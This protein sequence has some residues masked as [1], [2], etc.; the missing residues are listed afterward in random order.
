MVKNTVWRNTIKTDE[1]VGK[2]IEIL[3]IDWT[4]TEA[5][6]YANI[7]RS[8]YYD[9]IKKDKEFSNKM[10]DA[11]KY[12]FIEARKTINKAIK[13][14]DWKLALDVMRR[15]DKRYKDKEE[16]E[17]SWEISIWGILS[18]IQKK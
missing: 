14:W 6:S 2:L 11:S 13:E 5:C 4:I 16:R 18:E 1:V 12:A 17:H 10:A 15:R 8:T 7:D 9:W 3:R